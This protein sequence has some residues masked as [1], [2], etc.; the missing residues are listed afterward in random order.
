MCPATRT[1]ST[2]HH[3]P[4]TVPYEDRAS[5][6][7]RAGERGSLTGDGPFAIVPEWVIDSPVS[8]TALRLYCVLTRYGNTS[9]HR[10]PSRA[11]LA[12]RLRKSTDTIDRAFRDL[13]Q[14][15]A[16]T[17]EHR[18]EGTRK[19]TNRYHL[20]AVAPRSDDPASRAR[21]RLERAVGRTHAA[22]PTGDDTPPPAETDAEP[23]ADSRPK[24]LYPDTTP[25]Q[26][27]QRPD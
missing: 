19:L 2:A 17:V 3:P 6:A 9:G 8:D 27:L 13:E 22:T 23:R 12:T 11:T 25:P 7:R 21:H 18:H 20:L 24:A 1:G 10:M 26:P 14:L 5:G 15:G 16:L 4:G